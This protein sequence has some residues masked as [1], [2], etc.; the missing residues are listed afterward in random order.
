MALKRYG[1][2]GD[3]LKAIRAMY[4]A[5]EACVKVDGKCSEWFEVRKVAKVTRLH[6]I[7]KDEIDLDYSRD[8]LWRS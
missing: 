8:Q 5:S 6:C 1:V 4:Q 7:G 3:L 2:S